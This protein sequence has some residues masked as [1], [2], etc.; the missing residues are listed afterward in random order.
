MMSDASASRQTIITSWRIELCWQ[1]L[2]LRILEREKA[3]AQ[4]SAASAAKNAEVF[5]ELP[6][7]QS[8]TVSGR[9]WTR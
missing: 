1:L 2:Q 9:T 6:L 3:A 8:T 5:G 7:I 4:R